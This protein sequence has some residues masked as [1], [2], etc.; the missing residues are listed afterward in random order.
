MVLWDGTQPRY[1]GRP[2]QTRT[3]VP[4]VMSRILLPTEIQVHV[5]PDRAVTGMRMIICPYFHLHL[6]VEPQSDSFCR[7]AGMVKACTR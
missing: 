2:V 1:C 3:E 7:C 6:Q 4:P 5:H